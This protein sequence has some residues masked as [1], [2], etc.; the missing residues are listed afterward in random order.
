LNY[1]KAK[2]DFD[3][4]FGILQWQNEE[5]TNIPESLWKH[6]IKLRRKIVETQTLCYG[7]RKKTKKHLDIGKN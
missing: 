3:M 5:A 4:A 6:K 2:E 7:L 1:D